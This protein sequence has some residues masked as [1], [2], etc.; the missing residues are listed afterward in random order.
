[1]PIVNGWQTTS[2]AASNNALRF[3]LPAFHVKSWQNFE[4]YPTLDQLPARA[5]FCLA[6]A[7]CLKPRPAQ[8]RR[9]IP[10][11]KIAGACPYSPCVAEM[12]W[13][14][15]DDRLADRK[16][17]TSSTPTLMWLILSMSLWAGCFG[18]TLWSHRS[19][20]CVVGYLKHSSSICFLI[21]DCSGGGAGNHDSCC[22]LCSSERK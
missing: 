16:C 11:L 19:N 15:M 5:R 7:L 21:S 10:M 9:R 4:S 17:V 20:Q 6:T 18:L 1:M 8:F 14:S 22:L 2:L 13:F 3:R 12:P